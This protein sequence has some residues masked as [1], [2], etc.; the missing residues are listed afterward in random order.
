MYWLNY[1]CFA[2]ASY[3]IH[4]IFIA[5]V[6]CMRLPVSSGH[7]TKSLDHTTDT[8]SHYVGRQ[9]VLMWYSTYLRLANGSRKDT[10]GAMMLRKR[11]LALFSLLLDKEG[12]SAQAQVPHYLT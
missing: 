5:C 9:C 4:L 8:V 2:Y 3:L 12:D 11:Q 7:G 6:R 10:P 1:S